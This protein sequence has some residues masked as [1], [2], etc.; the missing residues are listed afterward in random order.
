[1]IGT[2]LALRNERG[3]AR[4]Q[5]GLRAAMSRP[6]KGSAMASFNDSG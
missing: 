5:G 2:L 3:A 6:R 1:M 4:P